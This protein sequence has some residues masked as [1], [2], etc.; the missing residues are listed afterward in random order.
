MR[1]TPPL[2][3]A[4]SALRAGVVLLGSTV[5]TVSAF[6]VLPLIQAITRPADADRMVVAVDATSL[7]PPP[8]PP[9]EEEPE[10]E[11]EP[12]EPPPQ[13]A[14]DV[15]PLDL[16]QLELALNPGLGTGWST[17][18]FQV[19]LKTELTSGAD[20]DGLVDIADLDQLPRAIYQPAPI[21]SAKLRRLA[22]GTV[23]VIFIVDQEGRVQ[24]PRAQKSTDPAF[25]RSALQ[26][27]R[28]WRFQPGQRNGK[29]VRFKM[30]VPITFPAE[31]SS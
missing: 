26:A 27:V 6:L 29:P 22:P 28:K 24:E 10:E 30:R 19:D 23:Y 14:E 21:L 8:P 9:P 5:M 11:P 1:V 3:L 31:T 12:D 17:L 13:L 4:A 2:S 15:Q 16:A 18:D 25:E 7:P 20:G